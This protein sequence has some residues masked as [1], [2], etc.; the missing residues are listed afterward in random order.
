MMAT[1]TKINEKSSAA[2]VE[3]GRSFGKVFAK[4]RI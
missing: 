2:F 1:E 3:Y 4:A